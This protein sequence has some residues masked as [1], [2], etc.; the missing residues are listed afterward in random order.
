MFHSSLI[1]FCLWHLTVTNPAP[2][3]AGRIWKKEPEQPYFGRLDSASP[4]PITPYYLQYILQGHWSPADSGAWWAHFVLVTQSVNVW[5]NGCLWWRIAQRGPVS[6]MSWGYNCLDKLADVGRLTTANI[7]MKERKR[8]VKTI[9][10]VPIQTCSRVGGG[11]IKLW[12]FWSLR[13]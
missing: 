8:L 1:V 2:V 6:L 7:T 11:M 4:V 5:M 9:R 3:E 13:L 10:L 12:W